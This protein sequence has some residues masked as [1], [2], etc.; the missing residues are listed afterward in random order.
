MTSRAIY[1]VIE[2]K[3]FV[4]VPETATVR[5]AACL[6]KEHK[7]HAV[8]VL[9]RKRKLVGI[10]TERDVVV[11]VVATGGDPDRTQVSRVMTADP[12]TIAPQKPFCHALH[13]MY[14]GGFHH[15]PVVDDH[16]RPL[17]ILTAR[18]ALQMDALD[19]EREL[20]QREEITVIL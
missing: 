6:M 4:A 15:I 11:G 10:C 5:Q 12:Q 3:E 13:M 16:G 20:V 9:S 14:E 7:A 2:N 18:D 17:G 1:D 8:M 19:F